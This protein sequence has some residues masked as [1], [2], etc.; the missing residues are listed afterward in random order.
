M[1]AANPHKVVEVARAR[2]P[3]VDGVPR[4]TTS[5]ATPKAPPTWRAVWFTALPTAKRSMCRL[6]TAAALSTGK[7]SPMP[8]P[9][10]KVAGS[11]SGHVRGVEADRGGVPGQSA[12]EDGEADQQHRPETEASGPPVRP[13]PRRR[14]PPG[15]GGHGQAG[16]QDRVVPDAGEE[17]DV[18]QQHGEE[19]H[20]VE[21]GGGVGHAERA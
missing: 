11:Q 16:P 17:E 8:R 18:A 5:R 14:P 12:G 1:A 2:P 19:A 9:V 4:M 15:A 3:P 10:I 6:D 7:V 21:H 20:G 13:V